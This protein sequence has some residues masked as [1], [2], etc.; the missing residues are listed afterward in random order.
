MAFSDAIKDRAFQR[1]GGQC[2]CNRKTHNNH[3]GSKCHTSITRHGAQYHH[4]LSQD[5]GG[6]DGLENCEALCAA[7]HLLTRSYGG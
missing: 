3:P 6:S 1:S 7:C 2:E 4:I 5:A